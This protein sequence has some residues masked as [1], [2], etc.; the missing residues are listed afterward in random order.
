[1]NEVGNSFTGVAVRGNP[2]EKEGW[3][4]IGKMEKRGDQKQIKIRLPH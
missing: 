4:S 2:E 1:M 3:L